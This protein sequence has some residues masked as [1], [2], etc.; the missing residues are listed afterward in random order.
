MWKLRI[1]TIPR[2]NTDH[3][4]DLGGGQ[5]PGAGHIEKCLSVGFGL[6]GPSPADAF[7]SEA[8]ILICGGGHTVISLYTGGSTK[9]SVIDLAQSRCR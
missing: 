9:P 6:R 5:R 3:A 8:P 1:G 4:I 7:L 2:Y